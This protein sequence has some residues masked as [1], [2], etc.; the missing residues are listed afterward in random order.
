MKNKWKFELLRTVIALLISSLILL[1][2]V[3]IV[4]DEPINSLYYLFIAPFCS[5]RNFGNIIEIM[6]PLLFTGVAVSFIFSAKSLNF[7]VEG[8][9]YMGGVLAMAFSLLFRVNPIIQLIIIMICAGIGGLIVTSIPGYLKLKTNSNELVSSL[10]LNYVVMYLGLYLFKY[11][12]RDYSMIGLG[13]WQFPEELL[14][15]RIVKG[16][17]IHAGLFIAIGVIILSYIYL[18]KTKWGMRIRITGSNK[19][20]AKHSGINTSRVILSAQLISGFIAGIGGAVQILGMYKRYIWQEM[21]GFG[22]DGIIVAAL[23]R[24]N[25]VLVLFSAFFLAYIRTGADI[26]A[27]SSD[28]TQEVISI[29][30]GVI[31]ILIVA[32]RLISGIK[33]KATLNE[34][35]KKIKMQKGEKVYE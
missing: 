1:V 22:W 26:M 20:F 2:I 9:F 7:A 11:V 8:S 17:K 23:A 13:S 16:T 15:P 33:H 28:V 34:A 10:M 6:I 31:I 3:F 29:I 35:E 14:L 27:R 21:P 4:S 32:Q 12:F 30:Q 25:P 18:M 24:N 5:L 19:N